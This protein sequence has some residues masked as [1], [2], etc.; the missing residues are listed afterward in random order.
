MKPRIRRFAALAL[1]AVVFVAAALSAAFI[2]H[3]IDHDCT[4]ADCAICASINAA[5]QQLKQLGGAA[6]AACTVCAVLWC[7]AVCR[8]SAQNVQKSS[9]VHAKVRM[10]N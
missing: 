3:E 1:C 8:I 5:Q 2:A 9:P 7:A 4:G 10:N 6:K